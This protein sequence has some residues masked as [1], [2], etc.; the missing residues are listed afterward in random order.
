MND[1]RLCFEG[2]ICFEHLKTMDDMKNIEVV[3]IGL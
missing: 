2:L 1:S 3:S